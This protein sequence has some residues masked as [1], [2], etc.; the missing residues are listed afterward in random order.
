MKALKLVRYSVLLMSIVGIV[1]PLISVSIRKETL[2][3]YNLRWHQAFNEQTR[4]QTIRVRNAGDE[5]SGKLIVEVVA[6]KPG[7]FGDIETASSEANPSVSLLKVAGSSCLTSDCKAIFS[8]SEREQLA[9]AADTN[10][11][12][13][14][15]DIETVFDEIL[16]ERLRTA[17]SKKIAVGLFGDGPFNT[18]GV[19]RHW[20]EQCKERAEQIECRK[21]DSV[22]LDWELAK[23]AY[24]TEML[25][26]WGR[27]AGVA[28]ANIQKNPNSGF[29]LIFQL[30]PGEVR[31]VKVHYSHLSGKALPSVVSNTGDQTT[32]VANSN[33]LFST[34][35]SF[36]WTLHPHITILIAVA[37]LALLPFMRFFVPLH[38][39]STKRLFDVAVRNDDYQFWK[40]ALERHRFY[41]LQ[42]YREVKKSLNPNLVMDSE[43]V[44]DYV[45]S[46]MTDQFK[47]GRLPMTTQ[48]HLDMFIRSEL[49]DL[50]SP[51]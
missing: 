5:R 34:W 45:R 28:F 48:T 37:I 47:S 25:E 43:E 40:E 44:I 9:R 30:D 49:E 46:R 7:L 10:D 29:A 3:R 32:L 41:I 39:I 50:V 24:Y 18:E 42:Q 12:A 2:D 16:F 14:I 23:Q 6:D 8:Q 15:A 1:L 27:S 20:H 33:D 51:P 36:F 31:I 26:T 17:G 13:A 11:H 4:M 19:H 38:L 21:V 22:I 35:I